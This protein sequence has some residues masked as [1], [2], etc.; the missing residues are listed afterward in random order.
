[1]E[2]EGGEIR[3]PGPRYEV[4]SFEQDTVWEA[5]RKTTSAGY[6][7]LFNPEL[8]DRRIEDA[9][10]FNLWRR[11]HDTLSGIYTGKTR[12]GTGVVAI[13]HVPHY[14]TNPENTEAVIMQGG[15]IKGAAVTPEVAQ[16]F[17]R[18]LAL[19]DDQNLF[20]VDYKDWEKAGSGVTTL[21]NALKH[22]VTVPFLGGRERAERY[23][24]AHSRAFNTNNIGIWKINEL[25]E[26]PAGRFLGFGDSFDIGLYAYVTPLED[27]RRFAGVPA[28]GVALRRAAR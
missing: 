4:R 5:L 24:E 6:Q 12:Q 18:L 11:W 21:R 19:G 26:Q 16:E 23:L 20:V 22:A 28:E 9:S 17:Q 13:A 15:M 14:L 3:P 10:N 8:V 2:E 25:G 27:S 7:A 1:M